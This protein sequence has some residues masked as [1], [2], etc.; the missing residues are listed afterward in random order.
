[1]QAVYLASKGITCKQIIGITGSAGRTI[2][3]WNVK[4]NAGGIEAL[5][6]LPR[7]G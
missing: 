5:K 4:Y 3:Q 1:M 7:P 6:E 2:Q